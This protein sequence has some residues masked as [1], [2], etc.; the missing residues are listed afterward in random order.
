MLSSHLSQKLKISGSR[1]S[2]A[3]QPDVLHLNLD[4]NHDT[5]GGASTIYYFLKT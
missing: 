1:L 4:E 5:E 2:Y 3:Y